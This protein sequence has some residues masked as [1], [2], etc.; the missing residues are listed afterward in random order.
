[1]REVSDAAGYDAISRWR[2]NSDI[3]SRSHVSAETIMDLLHGDDDIL[4]ETFLLIL[5]E[6]SQDT[7][8]APSWPFGKKLLPH[9]VLKDF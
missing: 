2:R 3:D 9:G 7:K 5:S 8:Q 6:T 1:M 4:L